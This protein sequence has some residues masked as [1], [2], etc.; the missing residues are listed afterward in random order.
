MCRHIFRA[1]LGL[2]PYRGHSCVPCSLPIETMCLSCCSLEVVVFE[3]ASVDVVDYLF[4]IGVLNL[5]AIGQEQGEHCAAYQH[6]DGFRAEFCC[7]HVINR[8]NDAR[9][10]YSS[11]P[12]S[13]RPC[14][15]SAVH[16]RTAGLPYRGK[17]QPTD[18]L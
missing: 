11:T 1:S 9:I 17:S 6:I 15:L 12:R 18:P 7:C 16:T 5:A 4:L 14:L 10:F 13:L 8:L 2:W 3:L